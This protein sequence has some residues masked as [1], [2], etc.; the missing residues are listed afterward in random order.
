[1][2]PSAAYPVPNRFVSGSI[3]GVAVILIL[4]AWVFTF[5]RLYVAHSIQFANYLIKHQDYEQAFGI[6]EPICRAL[7]WYDQPARVLGRALIGMH[8]YSEAI[9]LM[10]QAVKGRFNYVANMQLAFAYEQVHR[11]R[12]AIR[13]YDYV[14]SYATALPLAEKGLIRCN[15]K[16]LLSELITLGNHPD[17]EELAKIEAQLNPLLHYHSALLDS[18]KLEILFLKNDRK[19]LE[20]WEK[21]SPLATGWL[22]LLQIRS[23]ITRN[24]WSTALQLADTIAR[25]ETTPPSMLM[26][27]FSELQVAEPLSFELKAF[28]HD[29]CGLLYHR[30]GNDKKARSEFETAIQLDPTRKAYQRDLDRTAIGGQF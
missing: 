20:K 17:P 16:L 18:I 19:E 14:L 8:R 6:L 11:F 23:A 12:D 1:M 9:T 29:I 30:G 26:K 2:T 28:Y 7:P 4:C 27:L 25:D 10:E 15:A 24:D 5:A 13:Q 3:K 22:H 21:R